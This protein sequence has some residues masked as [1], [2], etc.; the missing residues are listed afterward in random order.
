MLRTLAE[1]GNGWMCYKDTCNRRGNQV[2][3]A[4]GTIIHLSN[5]CVAPETMILT[6]RGHLRISD[7]K[8]QAVNVWNGEQYSEVTVR[9]TSTD[10]ALISVSLSDSK[11]LECTPYH[12]FY[13]YQEGSYTK[14]IEKR[15]SEL[16]SGD[17]LLKSAFPVI[18]GTE[19]FPQAYTSGFFTGDGTYASNGAPMVALYGEKKNLVAHLAIKS[20]S[21]I[22]DSVGRLSY[23][24]LDD[25]AAK[26]SVPAAQHTIASRLAWLA[27]LIDADGTASYNGKTV[28]IQIGSVELEFLRQT[29]LMLQTLGVDA[30]VTKMRDHSTV[31]VRAGQATYDTLPMYRLLIGNT[32]LNR[33]LDLGMDLKRVAIIRNEPN[34]DARQMVRVV[35]VE[36]RS[37]RDATYC[38]TE[39]KRHMGVFNGILT[40]NCTEILEVTSSGRNAK[41]TRDEMMSTTAAGMIH[42]NVRI[43]GFDHKTDTFDAIRGAETAV[44]NL[45]SI[46]IGRGYIRNGKLD[47]AKLHRNVDIAVKYLDRVIDRNFYPIPEAEAS[48]NRW[49]PVGLGLMGLAD[50]FMQLRL[51]FDSDEAIR[52]SGEIQEEIYFQALKTSNELAKQ[53]GPH[54][55]FALTRAAKGD[56]QFDLAGV[57][58]SDPE[59][60][61]ELRQSI[62]QHGLRNSLL[63][64]IAPTAT[65]SHICG[66]EECVEPIKSNLLK[67]ETLSGEFISINKHLVADL[68]K[69][70]RWNSETINRLK[71]DEGSIANVKDLPDEIYALYKTVWEMSQKKIIEHGVAR[72]AYIDQS[73]SMNIFLDLNKYADDKRIGVLSSLYMFAWEKG[74]KTTYYFR[75]RAATRIQKVTVDRPTVAAAPMAPETTEVCESCT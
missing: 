62:I 40:G 2:N 1:T 8:D 70:G 38:F 14:Y 74:V 63:I 16:K 51:P 7:L 42:D 37:R 59:R 75:S 41:L 21:N 61:E 12:K 58:P 69:L 15:A 66:V 29:Q 5:L 30:K 57:T 49:R 73:Q 13:V 34:R 4:A 24:L 20:G 19:E 71:L 22:E 64:A 10:S 18:E 31:C 9:Q 23:R 45:G 27:G 3:D 72:G 26:Y 35:S 67:R 33:L 50:F 53:F 11:V 43:T 47:K 25:V 28:S 68:K 17:R 56:L 65:I 46:N 60:W 55:D 54:R 44:C 52:L 6:D 39:P 36:D 48:N 32:D